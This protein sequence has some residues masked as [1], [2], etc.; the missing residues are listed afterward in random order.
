MTKNKKKIKLD[1]GHWNS[2]DGLTEEDH[3][4]GYHYYSGYKVFHVCTVCGQKRTNFGYGYGWYHTL[5]CNSC[6]FDNPN[7]Q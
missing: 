4:N 3:R 6:Y 5:K 2:P 1:H 7:A